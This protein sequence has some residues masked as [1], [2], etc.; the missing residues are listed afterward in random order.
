VITPIFIFSLPRSGSTLLQRILAAH[1]Q[2]HTTAEPWLLLPPL[3]SLRRGGVYAEYNHQY[4]HRAISEFCLELPNGEED[5]TDSVRA[6]ALDLY[7]KVSPPGTRYFLDKTP[8]YHLVAE[9]IIRMFPEGKFIFLWRN[10]LAVSA[11]VI[12]SFGGGR[13]RLHDYKIDLFDGLEELLKGYTAHGDRCLAL[14]FED[15]INDPLR[16]FRVVFE[17]LG[18]PFEKEILSRFSEIRFRGR[19]G[20]PTGRERYTELSR[21]P[22]EKWH[23]ILRNPLR[24][25]WARKYLHWLGDA[26]LATMGYQRSLVLEELE[27]VPAGMQYLFSDLIRVHLGV[28]KICLEPFILWDKVR[29][30]PAWRKIHGC[31]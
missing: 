3:Y 23:R 9:T 31:R 18:L 26:R 24:K 16:E 6:F 14:K 7:R 30:L 8:R 27:A 1:P 15:M 2:V 4:L 28:L 19:L 20:D 13:W 21:E 10:P 25:A 11:S 5:Y 29:L 12:D 22:L 17:Y